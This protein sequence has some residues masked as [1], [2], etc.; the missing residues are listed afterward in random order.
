[1]N[2]AAA[3][4]LFLAI[5]LVSTVSRSSA[6]LVIV[7]AV[8]YL[9][10]TQEITIAGFHMTA[11]R[12]VLLAGLC[13]VL[14]SGDFKRLEFNQIDRAV[15]VYPLMMTTAVMLRIQTNEAFVY[16]LGLS[17][18]I[19][20][21]YYVF[22]CL[23][24]KAND[25]SV[26]LQ[27]LGFLILPMAVSMLVESATGHNLFAAMGG[28]EA[29]N[30]RA[31]RLRCQ[32][33]FRSG[34]TA[35]IFGATLLPIFV[36]M[37]PNRDN[38]RAA[39]VG[40][41]SGIA[42]VYTSNSS[43]PLMGL[44][45]GVSALLF[46]PWRQNMRRIR[47]GIVTALVLL[48]LV[49]KAPVW[50]LIAKISDITGG[51][52][53]YRSQLIDQFFKHFSDWWLCGTSETGDWMPTGLWDPKTGKVSADM[54]NQYV[55]CGVNGGLCSL[56]VYVLIIVRCF[57][58]LGNAAK[59]IKPHFQNDERM[60]WGIGA[61]LF[62]HAFAIISVTYWDQMYVPWWGLLG[63]ISALTGDILRTRPVAMFDVETQETT[64]VS[65]RSVSSCAV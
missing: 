32:G 12:I 63:I 44:L 52:G 41:F 5:V 45:G 34:I 24:N 55:A 21:S 27:R 43:G 20:L 62:A 22:R 59:I 10:Q 64:T 61:T 6:A 23:L 42:I 48:H 47:W 30:M 46:W 26:F 7:G 58:Q 16:E 13:R 39:V 65:G 2:P 54:T 9:T 36:M 14:R 33:A 53:W 40:I 56:W 29:Q 35:G 38:R 17:Y 11:I 49:M 25:V 57:R 37:L 28:T 15:A 31:G 50:F 4:L 8:C 19:L 3:L 1:M 18:D 60:L 51:D